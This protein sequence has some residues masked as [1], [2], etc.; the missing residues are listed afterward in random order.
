M[1]F[2]DNLVNRHKD[3]LAV[4]RFVKDLGALAITVLGKE[5]LRLLAIAVGMRTTEDGSTSIDDSAFADILSAPDHD[6]LL[7]RIRFR[8]F[9]HHEHRFTL[10]HAGVPVEWGLSQAQTLAM[11]VETS[12]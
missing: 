5:E 9:L 8:P 2:T 1:W 3:S 6:E 10:V 4:L 7:K 11:K 12:L